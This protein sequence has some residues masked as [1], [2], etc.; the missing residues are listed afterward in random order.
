[1]RE[2]IFKTLDFYFDFYYNDGRASDFGAKRDLVTYKPFSF[3]YDKGEKRK[4]TQDSAIE[5]YGVRSF[6]LY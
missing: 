3:C 2:N 6:R 4:R 5:M 1:M